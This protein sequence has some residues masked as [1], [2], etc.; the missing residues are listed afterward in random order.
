M[1]LN[2]WEVAG[3]GS[4]I[5]RGLALP[6]STVKPQSGTI[7]TWRAFLVALYSFMVRQNYIS[8]DLDANLHSSLFA[9]VTACP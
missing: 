9:F 5:S 3:V 8:K 6:E 7:P 4:R 2:E 1:A